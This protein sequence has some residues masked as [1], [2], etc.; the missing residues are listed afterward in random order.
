MVFAINKIDKP[1]ANPDRIREQ[2]AAMNY[3]VEEWGGKYQCQEISAKQGINIDELLEKVLLELSFLSSRP[4]P[5]AVLSAPSSSL[6]STRAVATWLPSSCRTVRSRRVTSSS[7][8]RIMA[9]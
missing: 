2:L 8:V 3:L 4:T 1:A 6:R 5:S 9:V 7:R